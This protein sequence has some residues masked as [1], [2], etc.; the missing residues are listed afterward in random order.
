MAM[1]PMWPTTMGRYGATCIRFGKAV[2]T[3]LTGKDQWIVRCIKK[4]RAEER[5]FFLSQSLLREDSRK[6]LG[7]SEPGSKPHW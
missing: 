2:Q 3:D 6:A 5:G 7:S 4:V 1:L